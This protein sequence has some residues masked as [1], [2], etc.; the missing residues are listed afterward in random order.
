M[1]SWVTGGGSCVKGIHVHMG[2][3]TQVGL[4]TQVKW[5]HVYLQHRVHWD[6]GYS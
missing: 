5:G 2:I 3:G 6:T 1:V 4:G